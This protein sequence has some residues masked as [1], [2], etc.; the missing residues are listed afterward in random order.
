MEDQEQIPNDNNK[1]SLPLFIG[2]IIIIA[3]G[4]AGYLLMQSKSP[5]S[6]TSSEVLPSP[7]V[8]IDV[9]K[10]ENSTRENSAVSFSVSG[11]NFSFTPSELKVK[12]GDKVKITFTSQSGVHDLAIDEFTVKTKQVDSSS[13]DTIE[14][15]ADKVG[16][17]E[18]YCSI[19]QHRQLGM[20]GK[21]IVE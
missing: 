10:K 17:F 7:T 9:T 15:T 20:V 3:V 8:K 4:G 12:K 6:K 5:S 19:G 16:S 13:S 21:L 1:S 11:K 2:L 14:F 18:Y